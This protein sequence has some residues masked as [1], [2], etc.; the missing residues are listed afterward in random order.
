VEAIVGDGV[1][2]KLARGLVKLLEDRCDFEVRSPLPPA[3]LRARVFAAA[4]ARGPLAPLPVEGGRPTRLQLLAELAEELSA[5]R[6][7]EPAPA[8]TPDDEE[9]GS[10]RAR[11]PRPR[12][13]A[14]DLAEALYADHA[15]R[16]VLTAMEPVTPEGLLH[17]YNLALVQAVLYKALELRVLLEH[18]SAGELRAILRAV[19]FHQLIHTAA[20]TPMG[21][22]LTLDGPASLLAQTTRYGLALAKFLPTLVRAG[23]PWRAEARVAWVRGQRTMALDASLGL[24]AEGINPGSWVPREVTWLLERWEALN[25]GW[26]VVQEVT[27]LQQGPDRVVVP[28]L[29][30]RKNG[31]VAW[32]EVLG[33]WRKASLKARL[34]AQAAHGPPHLLLAVSKKLAGEKGEVPEGVIPFAEVI[35]ARELLARV[36]RVAREE[37]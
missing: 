25:S 2:H 26:E 11:A 9:G 24:V 36:E 4:A 33:F 27:P 21:V 35:P 37:G 30:F 18:P 13:T 16:Q 3:L 34:E 29:G 23:C 19:K 32:L 17:R 1:D 5:E 8:E 7:A 14:E 28:D 22:T 10:P 15:E 20:R 12:I 6:S 31:R